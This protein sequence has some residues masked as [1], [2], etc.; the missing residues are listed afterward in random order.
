MLS[1]SNGLPIPPSFEGLQ[2]IQTSVVDRQTLAVL[3]S[4]AKPQWTGVDQ[5]WQMTPDPS[6]NARI[7]LINEMG[8]SKILPMFQIPTRWVYFAVLPNGGWVIARSCQEIATG[9]HDTTIYGADGNCIQTFYAGGAI[10]FLQTTT[11]DQIWI[12]HVDDCQDTKAKLG[13]ISFF[14]PDGAEQFHHDLQG[15]PDTPNNNGMAFWCCYALNV[16]GTSAWAQHYT[17]MA[18]TRFEPDG[19]AKSW[20]TVNNGVAALAVRGSTIASVGRYD[21]T[22]YKISVFSLLEAPKSK[23]LKIVYFDIEGQ[24][25][26]NIQWIDGKGDTFH[27][28]HDD[29]W[30]RITLDDV[31]E[32]LPLAHP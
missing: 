28:V 5:S 11:S 13:G 17:S 25:A 9:N 29:K 24:K 31:L 3:Y 10:G 21:E 32:R 30:Y 4:D 23:R 18:I 15:F 6:G 22:Q 8:Q 14:A 19:S 1:L 2:R 16:I 27:I 7:V 20:A 26:E 12:G